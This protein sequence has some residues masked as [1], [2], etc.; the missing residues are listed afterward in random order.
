MT[1]PTAAWMALYECMYSCAFG[2]VP[3]P[4]Q[5]AAAAQ[6]GIGVQDVRRAGSASSRCVYGSETIRRAGVSR[7]AMG[8]RCGQPSAG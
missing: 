1:V 3:A 6:V 4:Y 2:N 7:S 8:G 5:F